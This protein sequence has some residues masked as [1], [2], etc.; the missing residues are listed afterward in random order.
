MPLV[1]LGVA[2][3]LL[4]ARWKRAP[5]LTA[6]LSWAAV[7]VI[8]V[9][10]F[11]EARIWRNEGAL[12]ET[13]AARFPRYALAWS[14]LGQTRTAAGDAAPR[15]VLRNAPAGAP[16]VGFGNPGAVAY[17]SRRDEILVPN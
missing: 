6:G 10:A 9:M 17:D 3:G 13:W 7:A 12:F 1:G 14:G 15:R 11:R 5:R 16:T 8:A 2:L 4:L